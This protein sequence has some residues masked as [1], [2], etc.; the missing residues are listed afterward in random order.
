MS[1][2]YIVA[3][4]AAGVAFV[5]TPLL[6]AV[7]IRLG[8]LDVPVDRKLHRSP[9]PTF[10]GIAIYAGFAAAFGAA[11]VLPSL[12]DTFRFSEVFGMLIGGLIVLGLGI[13]D[14]HRDLSPPAKLAGQVFAGGILYLSG[15]QMSFFWL[16]GLGVI[17]L[18][19]DIS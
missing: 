10:G 4:V 13:A 2:Y 6:R 3:A 15:V 16:P 12:R 17:S 11:T 7:M 14:D 8:W 1:P 19:P 18:S 9:T 5:V